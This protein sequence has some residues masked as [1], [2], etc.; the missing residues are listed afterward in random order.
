[1]E[2]P[3]INISSLFR[4]TNNIIVIAKNSALYFIFNIR[5]QIL[6]FEYPAIVLAIKVFWRGEPNIEI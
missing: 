4:I 2:P 6:F 3:I 1:M 5:K